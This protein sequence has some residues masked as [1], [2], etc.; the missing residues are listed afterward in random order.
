MTGSRIT[1][2]LGAEGARPM[3]RRHYTCAILQAE[4]D[5]LRKE[6]IA[7]GFA[8]VPRQDFI[9]FVDAAAHDA[10]IRA[11]IGFSQQYWG[12]AAKSRT[13]RATI[14]LALREDEAAPNPLDTMHELLLCHVTAP[15][16]L[17]A[18][19]RRIKTHRP[20]IVDFGEGRAFVIGRNRGMEALRLK[21][22]LER[23]LRLAAD[24]PWR[25]D[26]SALKLGA[27]MRPYPRVTRHG[28]RQ[29]PLK[30]GDQRRLSHAPRSL[31]VP[32][33]P[34]SPDDGE[35]R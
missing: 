35:K 9:V 3:A 31:H 1:A 11:P 13:G 8:Y 33:T 6:L 24:D 17:S 14:Y 16:A 28:T 19:P 4:A 5:R 29:R 34:R 20:G 10:T 15:R 7:R 12:V 23:G 2:P 25:T 26:P 30:V 18:D 27:L 32:E 21:V 22:A